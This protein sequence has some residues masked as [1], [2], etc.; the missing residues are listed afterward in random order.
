[1][2]PAAGPVA[3]AVPRVPAGPQPQ[4]P[5]LACQPGGQPLR[6][7]QPQPAHRHAS[8]A[9]QARVCLPQAPPRHARRLQLPVSVLRV[10]LPVS[11]VLPLPVRVLR[12]Y[13]SWHPS[14][15]RQLPVCVCLPPWPLSCFMYESLWH[16]GLFSQPVSPAHR[17]PS[18]SPPPT[19]T[20]MQTSNWCRRKKEPHGCWAWRGDR[21][22]Q[23]MVGAAPTPA[24]Q[25]SSQLP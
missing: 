5:G 18:T 8:R 20:A 2:Q 17:P 24:A 10:C 21:M 16:E 25:D 13:L 19:I 23:A 22:D 3:G 9:A 1:M 7:Q 6:Q 12:V 15:I 11:S 14:S 4:W